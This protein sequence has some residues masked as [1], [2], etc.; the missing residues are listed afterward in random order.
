MKKIIYTALIAALFIGCSN[1]KIEDV[2]KPADFY[3]QEMVKKIAQ[4]KLDGADSEYTMLSS[5]HS[6]SPLIHDALLILADAHMNAEDYQLAGVY[7]DEYLKRFGNKSNTEY[8]RYLKV[9]ADFMGFKLPLR[10]QVGLQ[11][12]INKCDDFLREY[13]NSQYTLLVETMKVKLDVAQKLFNLNIAQTY[14]RVDKPDA[15]AEYL[16]RA[17]ASWVTGKVVYK[18]PSVNWWRDIFE[19]Q[20]MFNPYPDPKGNTPSGASNV[21]IATDQENRYFMESE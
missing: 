5:V 9:K 20:W 14:N 7:Y 17:N 6:R 8:I 4:G 12:S 3:Y 21:N 19:A 13:P 1:K 15:S 2:N 11:D 10:N 16:D 18:A